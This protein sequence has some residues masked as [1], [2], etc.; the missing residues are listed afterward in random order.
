ML[1][2]EQSSDALSKRHRQSAWKRLIDLI[3]HPRKALGLF[4]TLVLL[5]VVGRALIS[6]PDAEESVADT[7]APSDQTQQD[8]KQNTF[9]PQSDGDVSKA[10]VASPLAKEPGIKDDEGDVL[11]ASRIQSS[12]LILRRRE[13]LSTLMKRAGVAGNDAFAALE[14]LGTLTNLRRL[15]PGQRIDLEYQVKGNVRKLEALYLRDTFSSTAVV[16]RHENTFEAV[17]ED[18]GTLAITRM[19][20]GTIDDSLYLAAKRAGMP[21]KIIHDVIRMMSY[22]VDFQRDI[23]KGDSFRVYFERSYA[24][25]FGDVEEGRVLYAELKLWR[26]T[27][28]ATLFRQPDGRLDYYDQKGRSLRKSLMVTPVDG[29][30]LSSGFGRRRHPILGYTKL[31]KGLDFSAARGTPV[32]A[33]GDGVIE[34]ANRWSTFG[35]YVRIRHG[36]G[37]KTAYAHLNGFAK[38]ITAG[39]RVKQGDIIGYVGTTGRST[40]PH[41]HYEVHKNGR[42][43]NPLKLDLPTARQLEGAEQERFTAVRTMV[44]TD[45]SN[46]NLHRASL[47]ALKDD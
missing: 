27:F 41:L 8:L 24:P 31:H 44:L 3:G 33:A 35:N 17:R 6:Q 38:G 1:V 13:T 37:L 32:M 18:I 26:G 47:V 2:L 25:R 16:K 29:A 43:V 19:V 7:R 5:L 42:Q 22:G 11:K 14:R 34:R 4:I 46:L 12:T 40:G 45:I 20:E 10:N 15:Q 21:E 39:R 9:T 28:E 36:G 30:R 23:R